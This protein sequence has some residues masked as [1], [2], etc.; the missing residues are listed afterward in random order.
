MCYQVKMADSDSADVSF[1]HGTDENKGLCKAQLAGG[2]QQQ[3]L[4]YIAILK[5]GHTYTMQLPS[6]YIDEFCNGINHQSITQYFSITFSVS[7]IANE[8]HNGFASSNLQLK[9]SASE[10]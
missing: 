8:K 1:L 2:T 6:I 10:E 4:E 9:M 3:Q 5:N 7:V